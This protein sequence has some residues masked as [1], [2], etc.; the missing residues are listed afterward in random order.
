MEVKAHTCGLRPC[1]EDFRPFIG[2]QPTETCLHIFNGLGSKG[3]LQAP[4]LVHKFLTYL[5]EKKAL[6]HEIDIM[7]Y[8]NKFNT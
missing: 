7:R 4:G 6:D 3:A 5:L 2:S 1:T 8:I